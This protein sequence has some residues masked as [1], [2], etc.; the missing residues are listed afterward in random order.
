MTRGGST[1]LNLHRSMVCCEL[2]GR[3]YNICFKNIHLKKISNPTPTVSQLQ[4]LFIKTQM[5]LKSLKIYV[6][7]SIFSGIWKGRLEKPSTH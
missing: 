2:T 6:Y 7:L 3:G 5:N 1:E 4:P